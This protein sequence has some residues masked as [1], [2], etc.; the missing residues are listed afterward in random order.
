V[1]EST[2]VAPRV[3]VTSP[4][5]CGSTY[6]ADL[7]RRYLGAERSNRDV[8]GYD[9]LAQQ[10]L[11]GGLLAQLRGT[12]FSINL[13]LLPHASNVE[14]LERES[15]VPVVLWRNLADV[16]VSFDDHVRR[17]SHVN[18]VFYL[19][20]REAYLALPAPERYAY[21]IDAIV[22]W[23]LSFYLAWRRRLAVLHPYESLAEA[24]AEF[25]AAVLA[26]LGVGA[27]RVRLAETLPVPEG[28]RF[29]VGRTGRAA[30]SFSAANRRRLE[31]IVLAHPQRGELE[32][33]LWELP[34]AAETLGP[35]SS[36]FDGR[37]VG[38]PEGTFFVSR[39]VRRAA[40]AAWLRSRAPRL[41]HVHPIAAAELAALPE[42]PPL[43]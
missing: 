26:E 36:R 23:N 20:D 42:A 21:L 29:N 16:I 18:P 41:L 32:V 30:E 13:H 34:W 10:N 3:V 1:P 31:E 19:A 14:A 39:G 28:V 9:W 27:D 17:E 33:L 15:I 5:K 11:T 6:L 35:P 4:M 43:R 8:T 37:L 7:L 25:A 12:T 40:G 24:P 2:A 22:P 38:T